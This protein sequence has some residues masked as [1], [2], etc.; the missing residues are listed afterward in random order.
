MPDLTPSVSVAMATFM[1]ERHLE[2]QLE[3][4]ADQTAAPYELV[5]CDDGSTDGTVARV[6]AFARR[7]RFPVRVEVNPSRLGFA[8]NF[9]RAAARCRGD[10][11]AFCEQVGLD[12]VSA[13]PYRVPIARL[14]AAQAALEAK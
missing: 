12:Y 14:A 3:S 13:S 8:D 10:A 9:R 5:V 6:E 2:A 1:G 4:L 7:S 11:I